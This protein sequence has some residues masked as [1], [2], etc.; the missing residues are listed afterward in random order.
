MIVNSKKDVDEQMLKTMNEETSAI[1]NE[2]VEWH[3]QKQR[4]K[5]SRHKENAKN[6]KL[7][8]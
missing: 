3:N 1:I 5:R 8:S 6:L 7:F 4:L 2:L